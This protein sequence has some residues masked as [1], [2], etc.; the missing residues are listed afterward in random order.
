VN[1]AYRFDKANE[2]KKELVLV[3]YGSCGG[4]CWGRSWGEEMEDDQTKSDLD[5]LHEEKE[6]DKVEGITKA[7]LSG[8][9]QRRRIRLAMEPSSNTTPCDCIIP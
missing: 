4:I 7:E 9:M 2:G 1:E 8:E 3:R 6:P 5:H